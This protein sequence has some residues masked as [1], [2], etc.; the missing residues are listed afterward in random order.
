MAVEAVYRS[1][2]Q[3]ETLF[4]TRQEADRHDLMLEVAENLSR[5][6]REVLPTLS[7]DDAETLSIFMSER[8][9]ALASG[10]KKNPE[11]ILGLIKRDE[12]APGSLVSLA[13]AS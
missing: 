8:R 2:R 9:E 12:S 3:P 7:E 1:T 11:A 10:F 4:M 13:S 5:L 6:F